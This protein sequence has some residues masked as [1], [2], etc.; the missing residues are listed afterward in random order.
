MRRTGC[1]LLW[2]RGAVVSV[3]ASELKIAGLYPLR[4]FEKSEI[5]RDNEMLFIVS[6]H[7]ASCSG[8]TFYTQ[9]G[10]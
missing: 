10:T 3:G 7:F 6:I 4:G 5:Y 1:R 8:M 9:V 2:R